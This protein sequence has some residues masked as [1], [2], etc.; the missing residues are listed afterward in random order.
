[1]LGRW[2]I[3][4]TEP[5]SIDLIKVL[6]DMCFKELCHLFNRFIDEGGDGIRMDEKTIG[7]NSTKPDDTDTA[8][9]VDVTL[10]LMVYIE[11]R[12]R[13]NSCRQVSFAQ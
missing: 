9:L 10:L 13:N 7:R 2:Y 12:W 8:M 11:L 3:H 4:L 1:M 6:S 5:L